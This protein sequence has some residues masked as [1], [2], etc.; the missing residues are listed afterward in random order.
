MAHWKFAQREKVGHLQFK[1]AKARHRHHRYSA[2]EIMNAVMASSDSEQL[3]TDS[4]ESDLSEV[5]SFEETFKTSS[6]DDPQ[7]QKKEKSNEIAVSPITAPN[8]QKVYVELQTVAPTV[9]SESDSPNSSPH[10]VHLEFST[11]PSFPPSSDPSSYTTYSSTTSNRSTLTFPSDHSTSNI[12]TPVFPEDKFPPSDDESDDSL[13]DFN[14]DPKSEHV[15]KK[16]AVFQVAE[17]PF[18]TLAQMV[19]LYLESVIKD[20][21]KPA[22]P[23]PDMD[24]NQKRNFRRKAEK[25]KMV[26]G[27][28][29]HH[30]IYV[31]EKNKVKRGMYYRDVGK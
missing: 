16:R 15:N 24:R 3:T 26:N 6:P 12:P 31:D 11:D 2:E 1:M 25:F 19:R 29:R 21:S 20:P 9:S 28:L 7:L 30:H 17:V 5:E 18:N 4:D 22:W 8:S 14:I 27:S 13:V 10:P 23:V